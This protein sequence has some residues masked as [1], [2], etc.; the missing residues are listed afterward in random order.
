MGNDSGNRG[1]T[2]TRITISSRMRMY[3]M[4]AKEASGYYKETEDRRNRRRFQSRN[5][6]GS[7]YVWRRGQSSLHYYCTQSRADDHVI[8]GATHHGLSFES[9]ST[10]ATRQTIIYDLRCWAR[11]TNRV[12]HIMVLQNRCSLGGLDLLVRQHPHLMAVRVA[13][14]V[15]HRLSISR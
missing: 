1:N 10:R 4:S 7:R 11:R 6:I 5:I 8:L 14:C 9:S 13:G 12:T 2:T 3:E 15:L